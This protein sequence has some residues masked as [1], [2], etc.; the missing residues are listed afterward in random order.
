MGHGCVCADCRVIADG[1]VADQSSACADGYAVADRWV[2]LHRFKRLTA[3]S[4]AV[5]Q[6]NVIA[7]DRC[8][9]DYYTHTVIDEKSTTDCR[10]GVNFHSGPQTREV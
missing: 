3:E 9:T 5:I 1:N 6:V 7:N 10:A 2:A 8:F 4:H